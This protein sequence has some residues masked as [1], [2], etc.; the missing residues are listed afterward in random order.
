[1]STVFTATGYDQI[2]QVVQGAPFTWSVSD[3]ST[4]TIDETSGR[5]KPFKTGLVWVTCE[6]GSIHTRA[7]VLIKAGHKP[8]QTDA[9]WR[10]EQEAF[11][12]DGR[13]GA[14]IA[15]LAGILDQLAP[16]AYAQSSC[17]SG[18]G[19]NCSGGPTGDIGFDQL[20]SNPG[21]LVGTP[22]DVTATSTSLGPALPES[23][24]F[25]LAIPIVGL[26][27]L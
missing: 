19:G 23:S 17:G 16:T 3:P 12:E 10:S 15:G 13:V 6:A 21:N 4:A 2:G 5:I 11:Q 1:M 24:N 26:G 27:G 14:S 9:E 8:R 20:F 22:E 7:P 18:N 25:E